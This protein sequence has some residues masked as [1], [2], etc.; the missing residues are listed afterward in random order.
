MLMQPQLETERL[1]LRPFTL[2]D[3][4]EV[5][6]LAGDPAVAD[7]TLNLPHPYLDGMAE[8]WIAT[9]QPQF[10]AGVSAVFAVTLRAAGALVGTIGLGIERRYD[11]AEL[12]YWVGLPYWGQGYCTEAGRRL[13][14]FAFTDLTLNRV[15]ATHFLRNPSS[16]R[17]MQKLGMTREGLCRQHVKKGDRYEDSVLY[18]ILRD[19]W[20]G[21]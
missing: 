5:Q 8:R 2:A 6:R 19:E 7:T 4:P 14:A 3:A 1:L 11:R 18:G 16:G 10:A 21:G 12:G 13:L 17:V 9:H 20:R 15:F